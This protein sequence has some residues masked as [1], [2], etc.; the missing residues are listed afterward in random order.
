MAQK[1]KNFVILQR[2]MEMFMKI[3]VYF[4]QCLADAQSNSVLNLVF[5]ILSFF[6]WFWCKNG[7]NWGKNEHVFAYSQVLFN[8][9]AWSGMA[10]WKTDKYTF[11]DIENAEKLVKT[12]NLCFF[13]KTCKNMQNHAKNVKSRIWPSFG[14]CSS[15]LTLIKIYNI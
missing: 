4:Y 8:T 15:T 7:E 3:V 6:A 1:K 5:H 14:M 13:A 2:H 11:S 9:K 12:W 10:P